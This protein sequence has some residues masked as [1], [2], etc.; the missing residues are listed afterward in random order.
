MI[1]RVMNVALIIIITLCF[2]AKTASPDKTSIK[3]GVQQILVSGVIGRER[4]YEVESLHKFYEQNLHELSWTPE[5]ARE[6]IKAIEMVQMHGLNSR[7]YHR[8][9]IQQLMDVSNEESI[10]LELD[11][12]LSDSFLHLARHLHSGKTKSP[13]TW[14]TKRSQINEVNLLSDA[15]DNSELTKTLYEI[16]PQSIQYARMIEALRHYH[17]IA[18]KGGWAAVQGNR[19][20]AKGSYGDDVA[21]LCERLRMTDGCAGSDDQKLFDDDLD[22]AVRRFQERHGLQVDGII[23]PSTRE[24]LNVSVE[25]RIDQLEINLERYR[26]ISDNL[27]PRYIRINIPAY[28]LNVVEKGQDLLTMRIIAGK[29]D[30]ASPIFLSSEITYLET[31]PFWYVPAVIATKEIWPKVAKDPNYLSRNQLK[32]IRRSDGSVALQQQPGPNNSLGLIKIHFDNPN[33]C[34]LHDTPEKKLFLRS[35]R[36]FSHGCIRLED[37]FGLAAYLLSNDP[38][39]DREKLEGAAQSGLHE[40]IYLAE[41][42]PIFIL[43]FTAWPDATGRIQ[44]RKDIYSADARLARDLASTSFWQFF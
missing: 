7:D 41:P 11:V 28:E 39:W 23:G 40:T 12:L 31:N 27:G 33:G 4:L 29:A 15:L 16:E 14:K 3:E 19:K 9:A 18:E 36:A 5:S 8:Y 38:S 25:K 2:L 30:W 10:S 35:D 37:A 34:Y 24:E 26:W 1:M 13:G 22:A 43:Y 20:L 44:F 21:S 32:M 42:L 17:T 6:M